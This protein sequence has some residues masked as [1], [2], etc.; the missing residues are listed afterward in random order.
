[1]MEA[2]QPPEQC[3]TPQKILCS[4][5]STEQAMMQC[6][7]DDRSHRQYPR[8]SASPPILGLQCHGPRWGIAYRFAAHQLMSTAAVLTQSQHRAELTIC[9]LD[10]CWLETVS[11]RCLIAAA[12]RTSS[13]KDHMSTSFWPC[14]RSWTTCDAHNEPLWGRLVRCACRSSA[15][16]QLGM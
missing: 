5:H 8:M 13:R 12:S 16:S 1:M 7:P 3:T 4:S 9:R 11:S 14:Q 6:M 10:W 2:I 15:W